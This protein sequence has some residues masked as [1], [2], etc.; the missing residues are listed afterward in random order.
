M[1]PVRH[2]SDANRPLD[3]KAGGGHN[4]GCKIE[5]TLAIRRVDEDFFE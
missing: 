4:V 3:R 2:H 5:E 1:P